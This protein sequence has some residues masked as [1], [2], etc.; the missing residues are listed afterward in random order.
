M[1]TLSKFLIRKAYIEG[2]WQEN[3]LMEVD[4][5]GM[6]LRLEPY[7][8]Q[9]EGEEKAEVVTGYVLPS[10]ANAHSHAFQ[11]AMAG[12][13]EYGSGGEDSF[14]TWREV[15]YRCA[16]QMT[17]NTL[18]HIARQLYL[19]MIRGGYGAVCEFHYLHHRPDGH[20]Y[21]DSAEMSLALIR[22]ARDVGIALCHLPVLYMTGG[23][24]RRA[25]SGGQ[26]RFGHSPESYRALWQSL[27]RER[28]PD[29]TLGLAFHSLRAV[30]V[31]VIREFE[32]FA[33][34][35]PRHIHI[36]EQVKEVED[37]LVHSGQRP[38]S[39]LMDHVDIDDKWCLVHATHLDNDEVTRLAASGAVAGLCP[40]TEAN[41]GDGLFPMENYLDAG[42]RI[43]I[44]SDSHV[45]REVREE[46]RW[47]EY[48]QRLDSGRRT[49]AASSE[50]LHCGNRLYN[51]CLE[52]G[53]SVSGF[54][55]GK[56][57]PGYRADLVVL[58][59]DS[60]LLAGLPDEQLVDAYI[61]NGNERVIDHLMVGGKWV[62]KDGRHSREDEINTDFRETM[63]SLLAEQG[64]HA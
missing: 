9:N 13:A 51:D 5:A 32:D 16:A 61:F 11:R 47:L 6:I 58:K 20:S 56:L 50:T 38:V 49:V 24:D 27:E 63:E 25:L 30:P 17:P 8:G 29:V 18:Y 36:A 52:G 22:A 53:A 3:L 40:T 4:L 19:E 42:G 43:A 33:P 34:D 28:G 39:Y 54:R 14:W 48:G 2:R 57:A 55:T 60:L 41:L 15:M 10:I 59:E 64:A 7:D 45:S 1:S 44:G 31:E 23:F 12:R 62:L 37:S 26:T 35:V 21:E 46:L